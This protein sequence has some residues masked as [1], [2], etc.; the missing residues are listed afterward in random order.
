MPFEGALSPVHLLIIAVVALLFIRPQE[1]PR[2]ARQ[3]GNAV[4]ELRRMNQHL[5]TQMTDL[6]EG[7]PTTDDTD[8]DTTRTGIDTNAAIRDAAPPPSDHTRGQRTWP[9]QT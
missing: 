3:T 8:E 6:V 7:F 4:R 5:R 9:P 2:I 1:L